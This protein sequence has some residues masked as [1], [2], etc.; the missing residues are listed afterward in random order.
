MV[1]AHINAGQQTDEVWILAALDLAYWH[2]CMGKVIHECAWCMFVID[3]VVDKVHE[4]GDR[5]IISLRFVAC[6]VMVSMDM[7]REREW[8]TKKPSLSM[9]SWRVRA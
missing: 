5:G 8:M 7:Q 2:D 3:Q 1:G 4:H 6:L 9:W